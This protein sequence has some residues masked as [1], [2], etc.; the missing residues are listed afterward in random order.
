M[1]R[2]KI[3][4]PQLEGFLFAAADLLYGKMDASVYKEYI[5]GLLFLKRL[6]NVF[7]EK[8]T[9]LRRQ[10]S[11]LPAPKLAEV[12]E[13]KS[14]YGDTFFVPPRARWNEKW[15]DEEGK[16]QPALK[17]VQV[18][19]GQTLNKA[20]SELEDENE[21]LHGV[22]KGNIDFNAQVAG[23]P[24]IK[25]QDLKDLLD[26]FTRSVDRQGRRLRQELGVWVVEP[27]SATLAARRLF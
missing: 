23:K 24:K 25:N 10:Y 19:I 4:L 22:L 11:H 6:S 12:M 3:T 16:E 17:D 5:F 15:I 8:R 21:M 9:E 7:D 1:R 13:L 20:I 27:E 2:T 14:T 26:H 18:D